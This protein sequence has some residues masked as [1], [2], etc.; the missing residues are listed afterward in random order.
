MLI[1]VMNVLVKVYILEGEWLCFS[2]HFL[3][4]NPRIS[5]KQNHPPQ[6]SGLKPLEIG[7]LARSVRE[8]CMGTHRGYPT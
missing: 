3:L 2:F 4:F 1:C 5:M 6:G 7:H 8:Q